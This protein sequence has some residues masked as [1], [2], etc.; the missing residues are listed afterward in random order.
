[1]FSLW[2]TFNF[3]FAEYKALSYEMNHAL[4]NFISLNHLILRQ[5]SCKKSE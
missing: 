1:M 3:Q 4:T 5:I 2:N